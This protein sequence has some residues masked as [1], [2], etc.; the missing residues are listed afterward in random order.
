MEEE[1]TAEKEPILDTWVQDGMIAMVIR[2]ASIIESQGELVPGMSLSIPAALGVI[3]NLTGQIMAAL[4][5]E[6]ESEEHE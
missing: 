1:Q 5:S 2:N 3:A 4:S 6:G